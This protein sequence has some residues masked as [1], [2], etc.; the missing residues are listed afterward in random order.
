MS[1]TETS[2]IILHHLAS[3]SICS[4]RAETHSDRPFR[5][6]IKA[7]D[8]C[9]REILKLRRAYPRQFHGRD[10]VPPIFAAIKQDSCVWTRTGRSKHSWSHGK[11]SWSYGRH[12]WSYGRHYQAFIAP[13]DI[14]RGVTASTRGLW[15][16]LLVS[17]PT[18]LV[19]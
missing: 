15:Q 7:Q 8:K 3:G 1:A 12:S 17:F 14:T 6:F 4:L 18:L 10:P 2:C 9:G 16:A 13:I 19:P 5:V 11:H